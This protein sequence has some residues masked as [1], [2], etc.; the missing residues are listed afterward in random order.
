V[1][2]GVFTVKTTS[3]KSEEDIV[4]EIE[5]VLKDNGISYQQMA[6]RIFSCEANE[7]GS[8]SSFEIMLCHIEKL[9]MNGLYFKRIRGN[10]WIHKQITDRLISQMKL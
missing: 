7:R 5:R 6:T 1:K 9:G 8:E 3:T 4:Q 2:K 10:F